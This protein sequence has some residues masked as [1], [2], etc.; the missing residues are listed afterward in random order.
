MSTPFLSSPSQD[1]ESASRSSLESDASFELQD[2]QPDIQL[3]PKEDPLADNYLTKPT[4]PSLKALRIFLPQRWRPLSTDSASTYRFRRKQRRR[5]IL[6]RRVSLRRI[7]LLIAAIFALLFALLFFTATLAPSYTHLPPHYAD[8]RTQIL[9]SEIPGRGNP[10][11]EK[12]FIAA[13]IF[14]PSGELARGDWGEDILDLVDLLGHNN[15]YLSVYQNDAGPEAELAMNQLDSQVTCNHTFMYEEHLNLQEVPHVTMMD[16]TERVKRI[17]YLAEVRNRALRPLESADIKFDKLLYLNDVVFNPIDAVQLLFSTN[18]GPDGLA[19]YRAACAVDFIM[20]F[21]FYDTFATR[22]TEGYSMGIPFFPWFTDAGQGE[23]RQAVIAQKDAV[24]VR[25]CWGG[26]VAFDAAYFQPDHIAAKHAPETTEVE[27][28]HG[29]KWHFSEPVDEPLI[30]ARSNSSVARFRAEEDMYWGAS[31][32]CLI[33]ADIQNQP[34]RPDQS[35]ESG[36]YMNPYIR[37]AYDSTTLSWLG[38]TRRFER[39]YPPIHNILNH[40][41][42]LPWH[43]PRRAEVPGEEIEE[44][45]WIVDDESGDGGYFQVSK[46]VSVGDGFCGRAKLQVLTLERT[47][48]P[49]ERYWEDLPVPALP[50]RDF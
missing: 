9:A 30:K 44:T 21:K 41:T 24:P 48:E 15:V 11:N 34:T 26:M 37:V 1:I 45:M 3:L 6:C 46:R 28:H 19:N 38:F 4:S 31:E 17:A 40:A 5:P 36:I 29:L 8:L 35:V 20:P 10:A 39:L 42:R 47:G 13:S 50:V 2:V 16:G 25:S 22:D 23:S 33:H 14:D 32:C 12:V 49:G 7:C 43:N 27:E 18:V